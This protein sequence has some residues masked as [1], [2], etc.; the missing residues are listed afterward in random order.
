VQGPKRVLR[1][2]RKAHAKACGSYDHKT[3]QKSDFRH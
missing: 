3:F 1:I 2:G